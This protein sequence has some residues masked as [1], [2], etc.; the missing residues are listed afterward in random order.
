MDGAEVVVHP[1]HQGAVDD[2]GGDDE[3]LW[4]RESRVDYT[5]DGVIREP[6]LKSN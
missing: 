6:D 3:V 1:A 2:V 5:R 4:I